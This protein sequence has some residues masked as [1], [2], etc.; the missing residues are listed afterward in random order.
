MVQKCF[1]LNAKHESDL[2]PLEKTGML[3]GMRKKAE[4]TDFVLPRKISGTAG[5][6]KAWHVKKL[7]HYLTLRVVMAAAAW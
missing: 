2:C 1:D 7:A 4:R 5:Y 3:K 6:Y